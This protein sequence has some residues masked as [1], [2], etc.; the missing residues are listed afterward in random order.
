MAGVGELV[1]TGEAGARGGTIPVE[2]EV[3]ARLF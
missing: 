2:I 3:A 1:E